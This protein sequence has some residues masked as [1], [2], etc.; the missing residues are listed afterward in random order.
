MFKLVGV[1]KCSGEYE[2]RKWSH[3]KLYVLSEDKN[4]TGYKAEYLKVPD[5]VS[6]PAFSKLPCNI[7]CGFDRYGNVARVELLEN[8]D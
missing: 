7:E 4:V 6:I 5:D 3:T 2:G 8:A 1:R